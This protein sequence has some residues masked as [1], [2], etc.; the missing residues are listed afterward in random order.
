MMALRASP[1][2]SIA[3]ALALAEELLPGLRIASGPRLPR[4]IKSLVVRP[5]LQIACFER[6]AHL[7][8]DS[9]NLAQAAAAPAL[10]KQRRI[11]LAQSKKIA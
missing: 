2:T 3:T 11:P 1:L 8:S 10:L 6:E 7:V 5:K 9:G 4:R